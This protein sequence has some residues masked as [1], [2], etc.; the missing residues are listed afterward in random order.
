MTGIIDADTHIAEPREMW[1]FLSDNP[2][3]FYG[4]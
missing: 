4:L 1:N 2:R 3:A